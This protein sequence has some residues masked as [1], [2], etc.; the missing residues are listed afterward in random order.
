[1]QD[2]K[3]V[4]SKSDW[5]SDLGLSSEEFYTLTFFINA[6]KFEL[7]K[8]YNRFPNFDISLN[9]DVSHIEGYIKSFY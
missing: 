2:V 8:G 3:N 9:G 1:M 6:L 7:S 4:N 5:K